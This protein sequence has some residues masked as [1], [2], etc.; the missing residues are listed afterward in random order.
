MCGISGIVQFSRDGQVDTGIL[1]R[2]C[3]AMLHRGPDDEGIYTDGRVGLGMRRL[4]IVDLATGHQ[5]ISN[6]DGTLWIVFNGEIYNHRE[7]REQLLACGHRYRTQQRHRD[8]RPSVRGIR[9]RLCPAS[10]WNVCICHLGYA[11]RKVFLS[12]RDRLG[13]KPLYYTLDSQRFLFGSE[14]KVILA[15]PGLRAGV[16]P[17]ESP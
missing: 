10:A 7:L 5:P 16:L 2:M 4:S 9:K 15:H 12:R 8:Y 17:R 11:T 14:I 13:I 1:R 3:A 6:E